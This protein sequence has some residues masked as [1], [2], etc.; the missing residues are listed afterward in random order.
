MAL[1]G[2]IR[3]RIG[4]WHRNIEVCAALVSTGLRRQIGAYDRT[5][6]LPIAPK[7]LRSNSE[8]SRR[9]T[10]VDGRRQC[11]PRPWAAAVESCRKRGDIKRIETQGTAITAVGSCAR[12]RSTPM[13]GYGSIHDDQV[14]KLGLGFSAVILADRF[15]SASAS[16]GLM[17]VPTI[18]ARVS[19]A[20][21]D[22]DLRLSAQSASSV[23]SY[24]SQF[25]LPQPVSNQG[26]ANFDVGDAL[27]MAAADRRVAI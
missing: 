4:Q 13:R 7:S 15:K 12:P 23:R 27:P 26:R 5:E 8:F 19:C 11:L 1:R 22:C 20:K 6:T 21:S 2:R 16:P 24:S 14:I 17:S 18:R 25:W 10:R 9:K 3:L